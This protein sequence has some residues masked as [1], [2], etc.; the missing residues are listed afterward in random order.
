MYS[1]FPVISFHHDGLGMNTYALLV[2]KQ[3]VSWSQRS[4]K[5]SQKALA[6]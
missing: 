3:S 2:L 4:E 1:I 6:F 5:Y